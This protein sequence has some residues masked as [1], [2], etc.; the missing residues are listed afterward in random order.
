MK[1]PLDLREVDEPE[2]YLSKVERRCRAT[3]LSVA[4]AFLVVSIAAG[5]LP[6]LRALRIDP[7]RVI[8]AE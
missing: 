8:R 3:Y 4:V 7:V 5:T 1:T 6:T 2:S